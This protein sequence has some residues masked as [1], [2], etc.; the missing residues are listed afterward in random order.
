MNTIS[1]HGGFKMYLTIP[2]GIGGLGFFLVFII[3]N[4]AANEYLSLKI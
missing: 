1:L 4:D 2:Q 3:V